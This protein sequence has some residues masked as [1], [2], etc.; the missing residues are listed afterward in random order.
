LRFGRFL[1]AQAQV[2]QGGRCGIVSK[3]GFLCSTPF[4]P[5]RPRRSS[6][7]M[8]FRHQLQLPANLRLRLNPDR[9]RQIKGLAAQVLAA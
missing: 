9:A 2:G 5:A 8:L 7:A 3:T 4:T 1:L 6:C